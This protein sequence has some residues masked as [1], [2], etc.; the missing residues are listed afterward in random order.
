LRYTSTYL[1]TTGLYKTGAR[2]YD[3]TVARFTQRDPAGKEANPYA[4]ATG[5]PIN[6]ADPL[7]TSS[8]KSWATSAT[9]K[10]GRMNNYA[11]L[12]QGGWAVLNGDFRGAASVAVG[13]GAGAAATAGCTYLTGGAG[14]VPC[15]VAGSTV[16]NLASS[17]FDD[18]TT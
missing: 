17:A 2:Y 8:L 4:Y 10:I 6:R 9:K 14:A 5:D 16:G 7:G 11:T 18:A 15:S 12:A 3:P 13:W 1:D